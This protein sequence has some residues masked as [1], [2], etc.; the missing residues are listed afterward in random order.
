M[1]KVLG[2]MA[3][4]GILF[5]GGI[6][7]FIAF[8]GW[9]FSEDEIVN[10]GEQ[11]YTMMMYICGSD[12]ETDGGYA[13]TDIQEM[14]NSTIDEKI[15]IVIQTGGTAEW[16]DFGISNQENE[17][18]TIENG[19]L[20]L[21]DDT[22][23]QINMLE[24]SS[25]T[26]FINYSKE[27]F[28]A[29]RY[30][31]IMWD[32]G[33]GAISGFGYD[34]TQEGDD[35]LSID[36][37]EVALN[38]AGVKFDFVGFD[39]CLMATVETAYM[40][41]DN[42]DY[43][44]ASEELEPGTG[45][46]YTAIL[47][48][49]SSNTDME[50]VELG[51]IIADSFIQSNQSLMYEE[52]ATLSVVN[53]NEMDKVINSLTEYMKQ[54]DVNLLANGQFNHVAKAIDKTKAFADGEVDTID[55]YHLTENLETSTTTDLK[56]Q[57]DNVIEYNTTTSVM[58]NSNGLSIYLPYTDLEN[59]SKM[60]EI[61]KNLGIE[62]EYIDVL[63]KIA[64]TVAGGQVATEDITGETVEAESYANQNWYDQDYIESNQEY[65]AENEYEDLLIVDHGE[66]YALELTSEDWEVINNITCEV[67]YDDGEGY[68]DLGSD[69]YFETTEEGDLIVSFDGSW[70]SLD[71]NIVPFY[72]TESTEN[73][74]KAV[75]PA[76][77]N[78]EYV[79]LIV[80]WDD[81]NPDGR[82]I[83]ARPMTDY[84]DTT[85]E[86]RRLIE[87]QEGD[88]IEFLFDYYTYD[89]EYED[90]YIIGDPLI[91]SNEDILIEYT[92]IEDGEFY[93]YYKITDI[94]NN[95]YYTE[96]VTLY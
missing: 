91:V 65:Y 46:D 84:G 83:G 71:G 49:L 2:I 11:T 33:G 3:I 60:I 44:I 59:Y 74:T 87:L 19:E 10:K 24:S 73:H 17:R 40:L 5:I 1:K 85:I 26:D 16:Q 18:Y 86:T 80:V 7:L 82:V 53:V 50:T 25:L 27:N 57:L 66:Y 23:G 32:H 37:M 43:L 72:V 62:Q 78:D 93:V 21:I 52:E 88:V 64:N 68:I 54:I 38:N 95:V 34:E 51:K 8:I 28:P 77:L 76:Y 96:A 22:V 58:E 30:G 42:S 4:L 13:T 81:M 61:Y 55:L 14:I 20:V 39:A 79:E 12:L 75:V 94:Y 63:S 45:W 89:G 36:E 56:Q 6:I 29:D 15:N 9:L 67:L 41:K 47:N 48:G 35:T 69:D 31:L 90:S 70:I 92:E